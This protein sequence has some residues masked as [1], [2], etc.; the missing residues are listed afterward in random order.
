MYLHC[1][2]KHT[3][4]LTGYTTMTKFIIMNYFVNLP[5]SWVHHNVIWLNIFLEQKINPEFGFDEHSISLPEHWHA[6][7]A[8][9]LADAG[10]SCSVHL[11]FFAPNP[12]SADEKSRKKAE[13]LLC[14]A[15]SLASLYKA[16]HMIGHPAF[17][18]H[19]DPGST[20]D[21]SFTPGGARPSRK[22]LETSLRTWSA[23]MEACGA[24]LYLENTFDL[25]PDAVLELLDLL[26]GDS[27]MC[28]DL[29]HWHS[30][31]GGAGRG[32]LRDWVDRIA[33]KLRHLHLHDNDG[34]GDQHCG[35]GSGSIPLDGFFD[36]LREKSL[37]P[38]FTME[39]HTLPDFQQS[40]AWLHKNKAMREWMRAAAKA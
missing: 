29:G 6:E 28:F 15:A 16:R 39:P 30:F 25:N 27:G 19:D 13:T 5:L 35:L 14:K 1:K 21:D 36:L 4:G 23:V 33:P 20:P 17:S 18:K 38:T 9:T 24:P 40:L 34:E 12:G 8:A 26:P 7:I 22:W 37:F 32:N 31:A 11:P 3:Q 10:L 2:I